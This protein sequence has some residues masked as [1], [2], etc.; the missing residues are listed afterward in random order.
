MREPLVAYYDF[1]CCPTSYDIVS[2]LMM[3]ERHRRNPAV[4]ASEV[5]IR[6]LPGPDEGYRPSVTW[7][8]T[9][10]DKQMMMERVVLPMCSMLPCVKNVQVLELRPQMAKISSIGWGL[11]SMGFKE[12]CDTYA[13][14]IRPLRVEPTPF[15]P[16]PYITMTLREAEHW[17][18]RNSKLTEWLKAAE[19]LMKWWTVVIVRDARKADEH[20]E[21]FRTFPE[22]SHD[23]C[24]RAQLYCNA[25][26]NMGVNNGPMWFAMALDAPTAIMRPITETTCAAHT[27]EAMR[28]YGIREHHQMKGQPEH[29]RLAWFDD[30]CEH[31]VGVANNCMLVHQ[32]IAKVAV[33]A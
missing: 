29:Q 4:D 33:H 6:F 5:L 30:E 14:G 11:Y 16:E 12:F 26:L 9:R 25:A 24:L 7:P 27:V 22:A 1:C 13:M 18:E 19:K 15:I 28:R 31:I 20:L 2:F 10:E 21:G 8:V 17:P 3:V 32:E 23:L